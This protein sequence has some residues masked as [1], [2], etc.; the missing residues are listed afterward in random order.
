MNRELF[1]KEVKYW[2]RRIHIIIGLF[3]LLFLW[4][5]SFSGLL[6]NHRNWSISDFWTKRQETKKIIPVHIPENRESNVVI[7][8]VLSQLNVTGEI[9]DIKMWSDSIRFMVSVPGCVSKIQVN[10]N[11]G[12]CTQEKLKYNWSGKIQTL[13]TFNGVDKENPDSHPNWAITKMW[14]LS[15]DGIAIGI[16]LLCF[17]SWIMLY[18]M[19]KKIIPPWIVLTVGFLFAGYFVFVLKL[20]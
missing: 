3:L 8:S 4:L 1:T 12:L 16:I 9:S 5:F 17:S 2:N 11:K 14:R 7:N 18:R 13:H 15:L 6:M 20:I 10:F 19:K